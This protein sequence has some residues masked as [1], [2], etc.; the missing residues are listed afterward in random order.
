[1]SLNSEQEKKSLKDSFKNTADLGKMLKCLEAVL[2][3]R[4]PFALYVATADQADCSWIFEADMVYQMVGGEHNY[5]DVFKSLFATKLEQETGIAFFVL[6]K[7]GPLYAVRVDI[8]TLD[9]IINEL[10][11]EL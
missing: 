1:M 10:Y 7:V 4:S 5:R 9:E 3:Y 2:E 6:K 11:D 8:E